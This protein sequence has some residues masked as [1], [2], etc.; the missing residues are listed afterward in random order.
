MQSNFRCT[1]SGP[2]TSFDNTQLRGFEEVVCRVFFRLG[3]RFPA[4]IYLVFFTRYLV[5]PIH[6]NFGSGNISF[7]RNS[8]PVNCVINKRN[9]VLYRRSTSSYCTVKCGSNNRMCVCMYVCVCVPFPLPYSSRVGVHPRARLG[10]DLFATAWTV[11]KPSFVA[12]G[13]LCACVR[14][15][16]CLPVT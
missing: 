6:I 16:S 13:F 11:P 3:D 7:W 9:I 1:E 15:C 2:R 14:S 10:I 5:I 12:E 8:P 4:F